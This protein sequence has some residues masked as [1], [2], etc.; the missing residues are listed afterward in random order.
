MPENKVKRIHLIY[1]IFAAVL[2]VALG[3][4]LILSARAIYTSGPRPYTRAAIGAKLIDMAPLLILN[5]V[6]IVGGIIL[7]IILPLPRAK[8]KAVRDELVT[9]QKLAAKAGT[10]NEEQKKALEKLQG[11]RWLY[12]VLTAGIFGGLMGRPAFY[13][14]DRGNFPAADPTAEIMAAAFIVLPPAIIGLVGCFICSLLIK[15][16]I[17]KETEIY[18]Q[19]IAEGNKVAPNQNADSIIVEKRNIVSCI[20]LSFITFGIYY[21]YWKYLLVKN[22]RI[23]KNDKSD[24]FGELFCFAFIPFYPY[25]W[26]ITR[27]KSTRE[28]LTSQGYSINTNE[29]IFLI[30]AIFGLEIVSMSIM[31][32]DFNSLTGV[33]SDRNSLKSNDSYPQSLNSTDKAVLLKTARFAILAVALVFIVVGIFNG[34]ANDVLTKAIKICTECIGLG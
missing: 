34:S 30:L 24:S 12:P 15:K 14:L 21:I 11:K 4:A 28:I 2:L 18:K 17:L 19:I 20:I 26:W 27:G 23:L 29:V 3:V 32:S 5:L 16:S 13:L 22:S 1:G 8:T 25:F 6:A 31:Q 33:Y 10:P 9:M 7:N